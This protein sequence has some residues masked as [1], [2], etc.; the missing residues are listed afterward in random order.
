MVHGKSDTQRGVVGLII[1]AI[2]LFH[3]SFVPRAVSL[4]IGKMTNF[5]PFRNVSAKILGFLWLLMQDRSTKLAKP[6]NPQNM[7]EPP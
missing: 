1:E 2:W 3:A 6:I 4:S 5:C 7:Q